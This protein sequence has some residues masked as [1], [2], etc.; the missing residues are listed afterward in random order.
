[1]DLV[2]SLLLERLGRPLFVGLFPGQAGEANRLLDTQLIPML[3][4]SYAIVLAG[5]IGW[6]VWASRQQ[7][8]WRENVSIDAQLRRLRRAWWWCALGQLALSIGL[9]L[10]LAFELGGV[11]PVGIVFVLGLLV[12]D[13][14]VIFW[15]PTALLV[16]E[17][18]R[19]AIPL[20]GRLRSEAR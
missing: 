20:R 14:L 6:L 17:Q 18:L 12:C 3:W 16:P 11:D 10:S 7:I 13:L 5:Q 15:L 1:M 8:R 2:W 19:S 4:I 9:Q